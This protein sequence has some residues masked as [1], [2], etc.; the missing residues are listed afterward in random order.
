MKIK[1]LSIAVLSLIMI[2]GLLAWVKPRSILV[3]PHLSEIKGFAI[4]ELFTS[5]GCSSCPPADE[6]LARLAKSGQKNLYLLAFHVD[7]WN[8][9]GWIDQFSNAAYSAR[10]REYASMSGADGLYTPQ[11]IINGKLHLIGSDEEKMLNGIA[12]LGKQS[13]TNQVKIMAKENENH[14]VDIDYTIEKSSKSL[15]LNIAVV[16]NSAKDEIKAGENKGLQLKHVNIV[17]NFKTVAANNGHVNLNLPNDLKTN[18]YAIIVYIQDK[19]SMEIT[20]ATQ[21]TFNK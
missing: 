20:G 6:V 14:T 9:L 1:I 17:R 19:A 21:Y 11:A 5:E 13:S 10:Q 16:Q 18:N 12:Q 15:V 8:K 2:A 3:K 4:V 7:Y